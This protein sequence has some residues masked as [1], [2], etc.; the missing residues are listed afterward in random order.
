MEVGIILRDSKYKGESS[1]EDA[2][3]LARAGK[4]EDPN[5]YRGEFIRMLQLAE[6]L[7]Q[8]RTAGTR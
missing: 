6:K 5:G 3:L 7:D 8:A 2:T 1:Y 4:G